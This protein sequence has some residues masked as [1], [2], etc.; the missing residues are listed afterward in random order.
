ML[1]PFRPSYTEKAIQTSDPDTASGSEGEENPQVHNYPN[2]RKLLPQETF[3]SSRQQIEF[4]GSQVIEFS[5]NG[6]KGICLSDALEGNWAGFEG[7]DDRSLFGDERLQIIVRLHV[8]LQP[9]VHNSPQQLTFP[10]R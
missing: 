10:S 2:I 7:R 1:Q 3:K 6:E 8:R 5:V 9:S 4:K